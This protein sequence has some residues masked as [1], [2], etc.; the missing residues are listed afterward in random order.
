MPHKK[1]VRLMWVNYVTT[2]E[3]KCLLPC[4]QSVEKPDVLSFFLGYFFLRAL[5]C[6]VSYSYYICIRD[7]YN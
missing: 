1:D 4:L 2:Y 3:K 7:P 6:L 5:D